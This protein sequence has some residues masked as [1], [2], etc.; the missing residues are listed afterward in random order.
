M[1][2]YTFNIG[3]YRR[4][5]SHLSPLEHGVYRQLLDTYYLTEKPLPADLSWLMRMHCIRNQDE[6]D[7]LEHILNDF[8]ELTEHGWHHAGCDKLIAVFK[9]NLIKKSKAANARWHPDANALQTKSKRNA[10][11]MPTNN[12]KPIT[13]NQKPTKEIQAPNGVSVE[14]WESFL[15]QRKKSKAVVTETVIKGI[16]READKAGWSLEQA[17][18]EVVARGWRGFKADWV[19]QKQTE[20]ER[21]RTALNELTRG[22]ATGERRTNN[23][24]ELEN[25]NVK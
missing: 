16:R 1:H 19:I 22:L 25:K 15:L 14:V 23:F 4:D 21:G 9:D 7:A 8:F 12:H 13:N 17:L 2:Y 11:E 6:R 5:T 10:T 20:S 18:S 24:W 3:N